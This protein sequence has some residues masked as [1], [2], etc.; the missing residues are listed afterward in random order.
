MAPLF[1]RKFLIDFAETAMATV[2]ALALVF[3]ASVEDGKAAAAALGMG[4]LGAAVSAARRA[5]PG[6]ISY[7]RVRLAVE[8]EDQG[9]G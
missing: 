8:D 6:F 1:V 5:V 4:V 7:L 3:P 9:N 2:F